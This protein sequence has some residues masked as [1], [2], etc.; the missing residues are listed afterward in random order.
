MKSLNIGI[1]AY[2]VDPSIVFVRVPNERGR[3]MMVDRCVV[4]VDCPHCHAVAGEPCRR[5]K[6]SRIN[7]T[8][9]LY[10]VAVHVRRKMEWQKATGLRHPAKRAKPHK[11]RIRADELAELQA[12]PQES[13]LVPITPEKI[14]QLKK[15]DP[16]L[17]MYAHAEA[18]S[19]GGRHVLYTTYAVVEAALKAKIEH[20]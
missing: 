4:E 20:A 1:V 15:I 3:W 5:V 13:E 12:H 18:E 16:F 14:S 2:G 11:L 6:E 8:L 7:P 17:G 19:N 9:V 10:H